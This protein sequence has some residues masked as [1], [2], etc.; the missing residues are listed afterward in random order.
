[1][2]QANG[3]PNRDARR[4]R[5]FMAWIRANAALLVGLLPKSIRPVGETRHD[6]RPLVRTT[7]DPR[8]NGGRGGCLARGWSSCR[9]LLTLIRV[10][11]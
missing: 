3:N 9:T 4:L 5:S 7:D 10:H 11:R 6:R 8:Q 2:P 1:M